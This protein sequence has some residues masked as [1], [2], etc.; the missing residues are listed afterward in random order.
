MISEDYRDDSRLRQ[1]IQ[2]VITGEIELYANIVKEFDK[3]LYKIGRSYGFDHPSTED[4]MQEV[5]VKVYLH[6]KDFEFKSS[7]KTWIVSIMLHE[8]YYKK[9]RSKFR[10]EVYSGDVM[11]AWN[12]P[13]FIT[14]PPKPEKTVANNEL[15][16]NLEKAIL[17]I[18]EGYRMV[19]TL[20]ELSGLSGHETA[21]VLGISEGNVKV[22]L[23]RAKAM[24]RTEL[25]KTYRTEE[26]FEFNLIYCDP[27]VQRVM[28][29]IRNLKNE[30]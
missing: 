8:C 26:I 12:E 29:A 6:L 28:E 2:R 10:K 30:I 9:Y 11:E 25:E 1:I 4:L 27:L 17:S 3:Y 19:F 22:R 14:A 16:E 15:K 21:E 5:F 18:P 7:F 13:V 23:S 20:R 24:V